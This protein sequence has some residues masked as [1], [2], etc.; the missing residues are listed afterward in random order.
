MSLIP[1]FGGE[2]V[3]LN[4]QS[5]IN[6]LNIRENPTFGGLLCP[7]KEKPMKCSFHL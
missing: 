5:F 1:F 3:F 6:R 7:V 2:S 4:M